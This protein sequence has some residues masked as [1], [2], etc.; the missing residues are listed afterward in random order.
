MPD[1]SP[2]GALDIRRRRTLYRAR[3]RGMR[4]MDI[5]IG[6]YAEAAIASLGADEL[7]LF[8]ALLDVPDDRMFGWLVGAAPVDPAYDTAVWRD[9]VAFHAAGGARDFIA[10]SAVGGDGGR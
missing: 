1:P 2:S 5:L 7:A 4:E 8:E 9:L 10:A 3:H 6:G